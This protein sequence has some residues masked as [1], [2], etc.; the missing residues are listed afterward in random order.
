MKSSP[1]APPESRA[2]IDEGACD[3]LFEA[4][5][6]KMRY[7]FESQ[8]VKHVFC[9]EFP[10]QHG[11]NVP[12][13]FALHGRA[14]LLKKLYDNLPFLE[15]TTIWSCYALDDKDGRRPLHMAAMGGCLATFKFVLLNVGHSGLS[16]ADND[17]HTPLH[18]AS[19]FGHIEIV[20]HILRLY[21]ENQKKLCENDELMAGIIPGPRFVFGFMEFLTT[22]VIDINP[23]SRLGFSPYFLAHIE[24][25]QDIC[26]LFEQYGSFKKETP[27]EMV[28]NY[29]KS[30]PTDESYRY[31]SN[32]CSQ[33]KDEIK[34]YRDANGNTL[35]HLCAIYGKH[36]YLHIVLNPFT[37]KEMQELCLELNK[38]NKTA[39]DIVSTKPSRNDIFATLLSPTEL[40]K[41]ERLLTYYTI[42]NI[43]GIQKAELVRKISYDLQ[44]ELTNNA[45]YSQANYLVTYGPMVING[46]KV[47]YNWSNPITGLTAMGL[48]YLGNDTIRRTEL[49][50]SWA[51]SCSEK[52]SFFQELCT[53]CATTLNLTGWVTNTVQRSIGFATQRAFAF[54]AYRMLSHEQQDD[55]M[56]R[57]E[58]AG[59][60]LALAE[61]GTRLQ[62]V[63]LVEASLRDRVGFQNLDEVLSAYVLEGGIRGLSQE[64]ATSVHDTLGNWVNYT[65]TKVTDKIGI[66]LKNLL[67][68]SAEHVR[69][70]W[71][72]VP[73][74]KEVFDEKYRAKFKNAL[75]VESDDALI[76][77]AG[78]ELFL[79]SF[80]YESSDAAEAQLNVLLRFYHTGEVSEHTGTVLTNA[81][82]LLANSG[83]AS[84]DALWDML[85][86]TRF[87]DNLTTRDT[88]SDSAIKDIRAELDKIDLTQP[89]QASQQLSRIL[90]NYQ[91]RKIAKSIFEQ[92]LSIKESQQSSESSKETLLRI[93][94][95]IEKPVGLN[96]PRAKLED[97]ST[98]MNFASNGVISPGSNLLELIEA[99]GLGVAETLPELYTQSASYKLFGFEEEHAKQHEVALHKA[100]LAEDSTIIGLAKALES[101]N[102][103]LAQEFVNDKLT[104]L[105]IEST[106][107]NAQLR[108][109]YLSA[110]AEQLQATWNNPLARNL[111]LEQM[112]G[113]FSNVSNDGNS[114]L[115]GQY[116]GEILQ[117][118]QAEGHDAKEA[119]AFMIQNS[120][121]LRQFNLD[122]TFVSE[123][124]SQFSEAFEN[125]APNDMASVVQEALQAV[126]KDVSLSIIQSHIAKPFEQFHQEAQALP[127]S[128]QHVLATHLQGVLSQPNL[129]EQALIDAS[130]LLFLG[131]VDDSTYPLLLRLANDADNPDEPPPADSVA[132]ILMGSPIYKN[133]DF[134][135]ELKNKHRQA[136]IDAIEQ[137]QGNQQAV[138]ENLQEAQ[139]TIKQDYIDA[140]PIVAPLAQE[141]VGEAISQTVGHHAP[142]PEVSKN[143][144]EA[145][146]QY[147]RRLMP[148]I[149]D[150]AVKELQKAK[151]G[152][153]S[154]ELRFNTAQTERGIDNQAKL[155]EHYD[156]VTSEIEKYVVE[157]MV[158]DAFTQDA[159]VTGVWENLSNTIVDRLQVPKAQR[160]DIRF[161]FQLAIGGY[162]GQS[163]DTF[164]EK[165]TSL[166]SAIAS[167]EHRADEGIKALIETS[168]LGQQNGRDENLLLAKS[169]KA[170]SII[171]GGDPKYTVET[172]MQGLAQCSDKVRFARDIHLRAMPGY[173]QE[174]SLTKLETHSENIVKEFKG[175]GFDAKAIVQ[176][177]EGHFKALCEQTPEV[178]EAVTDYIAQGGQKKAS[179]RLEVSTTLYSTEQV[180]EAFNRAERFNSGFNSVLAPFKPN[181]LKA[182]YIIHELRA[183]CRDNPSLSPLTSAEE[184]QIAEQLAGST[185]QG[186]FK[187][188]ITDAINSHR[189][190][191]SNPVALSS[192]SQ[193]S[194]QKSLGLN[195]D[196]GL[197]AKSLTDKAEKFST[198]NWQDSGTSNLHYVRNSKEGL[199]GR[200]FEFKFN[201]FGERLFPGNTWKRFVIPILSQGGTQFFWSL[202]SKWSEQ[203]H[204]QPVVIKKQETRKSSHA[205]TEQEVRLAAEA[206]PYKLDFDAIAS[207]QQ[208]KHY[209]EE[210]FKAST[211]QEISRRT[212]PL[213][214][215][216]IPATPNEPKE[217]DVGSLLEPYAQPQQKLSASLQ[218]LGFTGIKLPIVQSY[219]GVE[220][221]YNG[222]RSRLF[223]IQDEKTKQWQQFERSIASIDTREFVKGVEESK[224]AVVDI[225]P[226]AAEA[227]WSSV[228]G[229]VEG[230]IETAVFAKS[231]TQRIIAD[232]ETV[233]SQTIKLLSNFVSE[234]RARKIAGEE[235]HTTQMARELID[236]FGN[237]SKEDR[238]KAVAEIA[239]TIA[240]P[241]TTARGAKHVGPFMAKITE[242]SGQYVVEI[243]KASIEAT[244]VKAK[245]VALTAP[246]KLNNLK[247]QAELSVQNS[248]FSKLVDSGQGKRYTPHHDADKTIVTGLDGYHTVTSAPAARGVLS[249]IDRD[250][251]NHKSRFGEAFYLAYK[252]ETTLLELSYHG[253]N[254]SQTIR[255]EIN[256]SATK[257]LDLTKPYIAKEWKYY[258]GF[259]SEKYKSIG[260]KAKKLGFNAIKYKSERG[261]GH[262]LAILDD[263]DQILQPE[264]IVPTPSK[265]VKKGKLK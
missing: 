179:K 161:M 182:A 98:V 51:A 169:I 115:Q 141:V 235:L 22:P 132:D 130:D 138:I 193:V 34:A 65:N 165:I 89:S 107:E 178:K 88:E 10:S 210:L 80:S 198:N 4:V 155:Q 253:A 86:K 262:N 27:M 163:R 102:E 188:T 68:N 17:G 244:K 202:W 259:A 120:G 111:V 245:E 146:E 240:L 64:V 58:K 23:K 54:G 74:S 6:A 72:E 209:H 112:N 41:I 29:I 62:M 82:I 12:G 5:H 14:D 37:K 158:D 73:T 21:P 211:E 119:A 255:Y 61:W 145:S 172:A 195:I 236:N 204:T 265:S 228:K 122:D 191:P 249:G 170:I 123:Q 81:A 75:G 215:L 79:Q 87:Y 18:L 109:L 225:P 83:Q 71:L 214:N 144:V 222:L 254:G 224:I 160:E 238:F 206:M 50:F 114:F 234:E 177:A 77:K 151:I 197:F 154:W 101:V 30:E 257:I 251:F 137:A 39:L 241:G 32:L 3:E 248:S 192:Y 105:L 1:Q 28:V 49:L 203:A 220:R 15:K 205:P 218:A 104:P 135:P 167:P 53:T 90:N 133:M 237:L 164:K 113:F 263:F 159:S 173:G 199:P 250:F 213:R 20:S 221:V 226:L 150:S 121:L 212:N 9:N 24:G 247:N 227:L 196:V 124:I 180:I 69:K 31:V 168:L 85:F 99:Q 147:L 252:P 19:K 194:H 139:H 46:I 59:M 264:M 36:R 246:Q 91:N 38:T 128:T 125:I 239:I 200:G 148:D 44:L 171:N 174:R 129:V 230:A 7:V 84:S 157:K 94:S 190:E 175:Q 110:N 127:A 256:Y 143:L 118:A 207:D 35:V 97:I 76:L 134:K 142:I 243:G 45:G 176:R 219:S 261:P 63:N 187:K 16:Y 184:L 185:H 2:L 136:F 242:K 33:F 13:V 103:L 55:Y 189:I 232:E 100:I 93:V 96:A 47:A 153:Q 208:H 233:T 11:Y 126:S 140:Q 131:N 56:T 95:G 166:F 216:T 156:N 117:K 42:D 70:E 183:E 162:H 260:E 52:D 66:D 8:G 223:G 60:V 116:I 152:H 217:S 181:Y 258:G 229:I 43:G 40:E 231:E 48:N 149:S 26:E 92:K 67:N 106:P 108:E 186:T 201:R 78:R 25:H 57:I